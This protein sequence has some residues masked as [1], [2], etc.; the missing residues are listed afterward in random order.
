MTSVR[1]PSAARNLTATQ[2]DRERGT[3]E[4]QKAAHRYYIF[5]VNAESVEP[6]L[7]I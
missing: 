3:L 6:D 7:P 1:Y 5:E 4:T 2:L